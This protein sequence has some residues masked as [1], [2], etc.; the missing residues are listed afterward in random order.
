MFQFQDEMEPKIEE[1]T[2]GLSEEA[3]EA[4][5]R[6]ITEVEKW[7]QSPTCK[8]KQLL[9]NLANGEACEARDNVIIEVE[10][11]YQ[12]PTCKYK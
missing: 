7:Y 11:Q 2:K 8:Y 1:K 3:C 9:V 10:K 5:D 6:V 12:I 4:H